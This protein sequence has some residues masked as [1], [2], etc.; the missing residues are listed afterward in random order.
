MLYK[1]KIRV[2]SCL[3]GILAL[4]YVLTLVFDPRQS[5]D[6]N[7]AYV[8]LDPQWQEQ[9]DRVEITGNAGG[10]SLIL[11]RRAGKWFVA[12]D[13]EEYPARQMR[14]ED[15]LRV[16]SGRFRY[17]VRGSSPASYERLAL[18]EETA[19]RIVVRGGAGAYPL[20]DLLIGR[21][22]STGSE[23]YLRRNNRDEVR[24][25]ED[26]FSPYLSP[27]PAAW[28]D[29]RLFPDEGLGPDSVQRLTVAAPL[30]PEPDGAASPDGTDPSDRADP[31]DGADPLEGEA[32]P[33][34]LV[35]SLNRDAGGWTLGS[36]VLPDKQRVEAY[37]RAILGAEGED[38]IPSANGTELPLNAGR[39][40]LELGDGSVRTIRAGYIPGSPN[41]LC[42]TVSGSPYVYVLA[43]WTRERIFRDA[44]YFETQ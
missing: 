8:W 5:G 10:A 21:G 44:A 13:G 29:L 43:D 37:V 25:G 6:R 11:L 40:V 16:L 30:P 32:P 36:G 23:V 17:P 39:I 14:I 18:T 4:I 22:D 41:R 24:S 26:R 20:L 35:F 38:F 12:R 42:A 19:S 1:T 9:V 31:P 7:A 2:L 3:V 34:P 15:L 28:Y 27:S 33:S